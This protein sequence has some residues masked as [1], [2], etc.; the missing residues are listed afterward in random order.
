MSRDP[1]GYRLRV[2][3]YDACHGPQGQAFQVKRHGLLAGG[4]VIALLFGFRGVVLVTGRA[5][6][7]RAVVLGLAGFGLAFVTAAMRA[8]RPERKLEHNRRNWGNRLF[9][10]ATI[11]PSIV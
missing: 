9:I 8:A 5:V 7:T 3:G 2:H 1:V 4:G 6:K 11:L 10:H